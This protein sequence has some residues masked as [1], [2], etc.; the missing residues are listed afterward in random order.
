MGPGGPGGFGQN[1]FGRT[2]LISTHGKLD[3][4][5]SRLDKLTADWTKCPADGTNCL[6]DRTKH[7][8]IHYVVQ[9]YNLSKLVKK[10]TVYFFGFYGFLSDLE[11]I[12]N[13][14]T[15]WDIY[16]LEDFRVQIL[17]FFWS[18]VTVSKDLPG[19]PSIFEDLPRILIVMYHQRS[20][21][22]P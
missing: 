3:T 6:E 5:H 1:I 4:T 22:N 21:I 18:P 11:Q 17:I 8:T 12:S 9:I 19:D 2:K 7:S 20:P 15:P 16:W 10:C 14:C 13:I